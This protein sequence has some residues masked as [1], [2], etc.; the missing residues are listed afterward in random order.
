MR[1]AAISGLAASFV[2]SGWTHALVE[3]Q[4]NVAI[5]RR[6]REGKEGYAAEEHYEVVI[7]R[8]RPERVLGG[9]TIPANEYYPTDREWGDYAWTVLT[10]ENAVKKLQEKVIAL[11]PSKAKTSRAGPNI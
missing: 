2:K 6:Y 8:V 9:Q 7:V 10:Y 5:Y 11:H 3:R 4:G 1:Q